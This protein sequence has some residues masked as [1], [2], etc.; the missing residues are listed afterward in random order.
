VCQQEEINLFHQVEITATARFQ[1]KNDPPPSGDKY[2]NWI[3]K[4]LNPAQND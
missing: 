3:F 4:N 1:K 2:G